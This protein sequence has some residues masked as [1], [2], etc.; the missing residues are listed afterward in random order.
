LADPSS[1]EDDGAVEEVGLDSATDD[2]MFDLIDRELG[3][4]RGA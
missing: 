3:G 2:E 4:S 1:D